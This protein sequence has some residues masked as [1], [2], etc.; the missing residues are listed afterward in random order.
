MSDTHRKLY[1]IIKEAYIKKAKEE[2]GK[3]QYKDIENKYPYLMM[4]IDNPSLLVS[5]I[6]EESDTA[7]KVLDILYH[8]LS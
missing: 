4:A 2:G 6:K 7:F 1:N 8:G 3:I 5:R